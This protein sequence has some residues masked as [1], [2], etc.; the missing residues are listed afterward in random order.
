MDIPDT[1]PPALKKACIDNYNYALCLKSGE[2]IYF[3]EA[4]PIDADWINILSPQ[5]P[6][7]FTGRVITRGL[8]VRLSEIVWCLDDF[9]R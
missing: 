3:C 9:D 6:G 5:G 7:I 1:Y 4:R 8:N 2:I